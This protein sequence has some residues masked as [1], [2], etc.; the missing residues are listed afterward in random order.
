MQE[1]YVTEVEAADSWTEKTKHENLAIFDL[2]VEV[3][4]D[5][6]VSAVTRKLMTEYKSVLMKN[7]HRT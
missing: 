2:F 1:L 7:S 5:I 3:H 4:G 6:M